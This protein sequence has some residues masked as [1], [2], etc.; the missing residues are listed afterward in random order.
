MPA[1]A[2]GTAAGRG[3]T[4][5]GAREWGKAGR[6]AKAS[7]QA[8]L[9]LPESGE[10]RA[11]DVRLVHRSLCLRTSKQ[12]TESWDLPVLHE[13]VHGRRGACAEHAP[14]HRPPRWWWCVFDTRPST[15]QGCYYFKIV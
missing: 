13:G 7:G 5:V 10:R 14:P 4:S 12:A 1:L 8:L 3:G 2:L 9:L 11:A 6:A 15:G